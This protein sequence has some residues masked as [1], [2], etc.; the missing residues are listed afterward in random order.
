[1][2]VVTRQWLLL[3]GC[4]PYRPHTC[5]PLERLQMTR[6]RPL[7]VKQELSRLRARF[8]VIPKLVTTGLIV[9]E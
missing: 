4:R 3:A 2:Y 6:M 9:T 1:M 8:P 5:S 7:S